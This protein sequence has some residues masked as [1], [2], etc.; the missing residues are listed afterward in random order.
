MINQSDQNRNVFLKEDSL[1]SELLACPWCNS[2]SYKKEIEIQVN[3][4]ID[5]RSCSKCHIG[6][7]SR[8]PH[9]TYL[10][11]YYQNYYSGKKNNVNADSNRFA[12][13]IITEKKHDETI[14]IVDFGGGDGS[15]AISIAGL[16]IKQGVKLV[17]VIVV[18]PN[19]QPQTLP[20]PLIKVSNVND[21]SDINGTYD[22]V[23]ASAVLEHLKTPKLHL[24][25]LLGILKPEGLFYARTPYLFPMAKTLRKMG[26]N[27]GTQFPAHLFDMGKEFWE[28][29][30][31]EDWFENE[32]R[33]IK[34]KPSLVEKSF[35]QNPINNVI[36]NM[37]KAPYKI[38]PD[39]YKTVAGWEIYISKLLK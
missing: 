31:S 13:R 22:Y 18:D 5:F 30:P 35:A 9:L 27:V 23:L 38:A 4:D 33:I 14:S 37:I 25:G 28:Q 7:A 8:Q 2:K 29:I 20:N 15:V 32:Y 39:K 34:S 17:N 3:P 21:L 19:F 24:Q 10:S 12:K 1:E 16:L 36:G 6:Y 26:V 11:E